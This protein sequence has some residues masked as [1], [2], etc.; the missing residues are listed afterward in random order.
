MRRPSVCVG[1][2]WQ[3]PGELAGTA[4]GALLRGGAMAAMPGHWCTCTCT[5]RGWQLA[6]QCHVDIDIGRSRI[7]R[8]RSPSGWG[9]AVPLRAAATTTAWV[10]PLPLPSSRS[11]S[12]A[13]SASCRR[14]R[15]FGTTYKSQANPILSASL[16]WAIDLW[17][18]SCAGL[19]TVRIGG[20]WEMRAE[21]RSVFRGQYGGFS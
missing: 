8:N 7:S 21:A 13:S 15:G 12:S 17:D 4:P 2:D 16:I 3:G 1:G 10:L 14:P 19:R 18:F 20:Q 11:S 6:V 9:F 5:C